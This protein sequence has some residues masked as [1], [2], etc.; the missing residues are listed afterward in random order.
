MLRYTGRVSAK[1]LRLRTKPRICSLFRSRVYVSLSADVQTG[2]LSD[3]KQRR[4]GCYYS[5]ANIGEENRFIITTRSG[6]A[7]R[8]VVVLSTN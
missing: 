8:R 3:V 5:G 1:S 6:Q 2:S 7:P 4:N